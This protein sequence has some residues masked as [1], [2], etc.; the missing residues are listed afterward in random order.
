MFF[1]SISLF[2]IFFYFNFF[3]FSHFYNHSYFNNAF[4]SITKIDINGNTYIYFFNFVL[5][6]NI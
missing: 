2:S 1:L 5:S 3:M 4:I 6:N